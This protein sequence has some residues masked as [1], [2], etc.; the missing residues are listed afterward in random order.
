[1]EDPNC[2]TAKM[3]RVQIAVSEHP[4]HAISSPN[5]PLITPSL[6]NILFH[7]MATATLEPIMEGR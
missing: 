6:A 7:R 1:M 2:H 5:R 4:S 3:I